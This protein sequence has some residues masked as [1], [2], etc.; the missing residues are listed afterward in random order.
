[1][2]YQIDTEENNW[3]NLYINEIATQK[4]IHICDSLKPFTQQKS[5]KSMPLN[6]PSKKT[7]DNSKKPVY[8]I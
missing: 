1:M 4:V 2:S 7:K 3:I 6:Q 5:Q 8:I